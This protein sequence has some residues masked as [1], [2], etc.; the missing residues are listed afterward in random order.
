MIEADRIA[1][2]VRKRNKKLQ[3]EALIDLG[4]GAFW[5]TVIYGSLLVLSCVWFM[6][7]RVDSP[8]TWAFWLTVGTAGCCGLV[9]WRQVEPMRGIAPMTDTQRALTFI[10]QASPNVLYFSPLHAGAGLVELMSS[11]FRPFFDGLGQYLN[12]VSESPDVQTQAAEILVQT[13][14]GLPL[15]SVGSPEALL[16]LRQLKLVRIEIRGVTDTL[17]PT[18]RGERLLRLSPK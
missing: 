8:E 7:V 17:L 5:L 6:R 15:R 2:L 16:L 18:E 14:N 4:I 11:G 3:N 1:K 9:A 13:A 12:R 10:S